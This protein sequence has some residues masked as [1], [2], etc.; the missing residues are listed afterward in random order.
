MIPICNF[1]FIFKE[2]LTLESK[3]KS[4]IALENLYSSRKLPLTAFNRIQA[5]EKISNVEK[6]S[7]FPHDYIKVNKGIVEEVINFGYLF[8]RLLEYNAT[9][10]AYMITFIYLEYQHLFFKLSARSKLFRDS[11]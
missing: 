2:L 9:I 1:K 6:P 4:S 10:N 7:S 3:S 5:A 11:P 8:I